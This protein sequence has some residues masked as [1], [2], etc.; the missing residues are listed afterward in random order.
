MAYNQLDD[1]HMKVIA[2]SY[3]KLFCID[4]SHN[5]L[6]SFT[7][8]IMT[9]AGLPELKMLYTIG[10][11]IMLAPNYR[12]V[13]KTKL[14]KLKVLDGTPTLNEPE[15]TKKK[16]KPQGV[17]GMSTYSQRANA[18]IDPATLVGDVLENVTIDLHFRV[19]HNVDG[20]YLTEDTCKPE[21]LE[22]L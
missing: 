12:N 6:E 19:L 2:R 3:P 14:N 10:N 4:I 13:L 8:T 21:I 11:P 20:V 15:G 7:Q 22:T 9:L 5:R 16:K 17:S 18:T 1:G